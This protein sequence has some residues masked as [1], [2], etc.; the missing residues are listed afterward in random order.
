[1]L[2]LLPK[3]APIQIK[4]SGGKPNVA[5]AHQQFNEG[6]LAALC[7]APVKNLRDG[8][9]VVVMNDFVDVDFRE[10]R[11]SIMH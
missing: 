3:I 8:L 1:M 2:E 10:P 9:A 11:V 7:N 5:P 4:S 6:K